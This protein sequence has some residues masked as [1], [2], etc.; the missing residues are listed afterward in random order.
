MSPNLTHVTQ[1]QTRPSNNQDKH[2]DQVS[3][4]KESTPQLV[5]TSTCT[6]WARTGDF[7][8]TVVQ[9]DE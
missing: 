6:K 2:S 3:E 9:Q 8:D 5:F 1:F 7:S 4:S